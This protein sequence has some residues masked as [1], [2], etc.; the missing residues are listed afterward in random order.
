MDLAWRHRELARRFSAHSATLACAWTWMHSCDV[1][2]KARICYTIWQSVWICTQQAFDVIT[3][4][5]PLF[6]YGCL[7]RN[8]LICRPSHVWTHGLFPIRLLQRGGIFED[9]DALSPCLWSKILK[10]K[11]SLWSKENSK[12]RWESQGYAKM[13]PWR[14]QRRSLAR[15]VVF[16]YAL[17]MAGAGRLTTQLCFHTIHLLCAFGWKITAHPAMLLSITLWS[18]AARRNP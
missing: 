18:R 13:L 5:L 16:I 3:F 12:W 17:Q 6:N 10:S 8:G 2:K 14:W 11:W 9:V 1:Q 4:L 15:M 7:L